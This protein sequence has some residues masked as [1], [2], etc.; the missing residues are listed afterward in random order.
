MSKPIKVVVVVVVIAVVVFVTFKKN[1]GPK[2]ILVQKK[3]ESKKILN[4]KI[5]GK[6]IWL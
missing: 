4:T 2:K 3:V 5:L 1:F 6:I